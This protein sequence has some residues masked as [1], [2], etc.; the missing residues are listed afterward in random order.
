MKTHAI[1]IY[2]Q[3][4]GEYQV[5]H[6]VQIMM[7]ET[8]LKFYLL[9][10]YENNVAQYHIYEVN[11]GTLFLQD[12][13]RMSKLTMGRMLEQLKDYGLLQEWLEKLLRERLKCEKS[14]Q[15]PSVG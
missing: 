2:V 5:L 1:R 12:I 14:I 4:P 3:R 15:D 8:Y 7:G 10:R 11:Y 13:G 6:S 9:K